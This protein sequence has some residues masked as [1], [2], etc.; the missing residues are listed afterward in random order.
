MSGR[1][2]DS[3]FAWSHHA[4]ILVIE[5]DA[6]ISDVVCSTLCGAGF[7]CIPAYSGTEARLLLD[8]KDVFDLVICDL[9]LPGIPGEE[10]VS[11]IRTKSAVPILVTSAKAQVVDRVALLHMGADDYLVKPFDLDELVARVEALIRR[12]MRPVGVLGESAAPKLASSSNSTS[13]TANSSAPSQTYGK[14]KLYEDARKLEAAGTPVKLTR[15]EFDIVAALMRRPSK[16]FT[17]RELYREV[18]HEDAAVE[19]KAINTHVSNIRTKLK[20][21]GT[22]SY[23]ETVWGIGFKLAELEKLEELSELE[24]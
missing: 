10:V 21:T 9:M 19:E 18:W 20:G 12:S 11:L 1:E 23:I 16:V 15:T 5:D 4:K 14:W 17:K 8:Q 3:R 13:L 2:A 7:C 22:E 24:Q 6:A